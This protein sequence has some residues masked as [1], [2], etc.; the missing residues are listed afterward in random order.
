MKIP[1]TE[2]NKFWRPS[3]IES[4]EGF[5]LHILSIS[6]L[7][8][9]IGEKK[10]KCVG[11]G[12]HLQPIIIIIGPTLTDIKEYYVWYDNITYKFDSFLNTL[13][14]AFKLIFVL[15][16]S[17]NVES[18]QV[19]Q[20]IQRKMYK[21]TTKFDQKLYSSVTAFISDLNQH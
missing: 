13:D 7:D 19:W 8:R 4:R 9:V 10:V 20:F 14:I 2:K 16:V 12:T 11:L 1:K 17:F 6:D 15:N 18:L 3:I 5:V 21:V